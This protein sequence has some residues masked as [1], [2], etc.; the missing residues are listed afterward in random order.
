MSDQEKGQ[1]AQ[2]M[3]SLPPI[4]QAKAEGFVQGLAAAMGM[5]VDKSQAPAG[6]GRT[7]DD[8]EVENG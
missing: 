4:L 2:K 1:I 5:P 3:A 6:A 8:E 7:N